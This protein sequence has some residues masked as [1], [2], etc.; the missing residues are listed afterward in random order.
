[1]NEETQQPEETTIP[2][3]PT[4]EAQLEQPT[5]VEPVA[6]TEPAAPAE[7]TP[8]AT[9]TPDLQSQLDT[10]RAQLTT[11]RIN[12]ALE[13]EASALGFHNVRDVQRLADLASITVADDDIGPFQLLA[14]LIDVIDTSLEI[15]RMDSQ[16][17][18]L[19]VRVVFSYR[20][21]QV[22]NGPH[23][24]INYLKDFHETF[25]TRFAPRKSPK[26]ND[27]QDTNKDEISPPMIR[28]RIN[29]MTALK[30]IS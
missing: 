27:T 17:L 24:G 8:P 26:E 12:H 5:P 22:T 6:S 19:K 10:L 29:E 15:L 30:N 25:F 13:R 16:N 2:V 4:T 7:Q 28:V 3:E 20:I 14:K 21:G 18:P 11:E 1:M 9:P 23:R